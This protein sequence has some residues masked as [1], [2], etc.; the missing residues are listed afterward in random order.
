M[1]YLP[2]FKN[3]NQKVPLLLFSYFHWRQLYRDYV[4]GTYKIKLNVLLTFKFSD[5]VNTIPHCPFYL[6]FR[7]I[8]CC[9]YGMIYSRPDTSVAD[10]DPVSSWPLDTGW[11]KSKDPDPGWT[12]WIIFPRAQK[13]FFGLKYLNSLMRIR[14]GKKLD[15]GSEMEKC[16]IRDRDPRWKKRI[17]DKHP[18]SATLPD[19]SLS[20]SLTLNLGNV[21]K[22]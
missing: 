3:K 11:V 1:W 10:P 9:E 20:P 16:R 17:R 12:T 14:D 5:R 19:T 15:P 2:H 7:N 6:C 8:E 13:P 18:G 4:W 22:R 21:K